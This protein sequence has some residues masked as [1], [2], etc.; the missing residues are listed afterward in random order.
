MT[1]ERKSTR[2]D[3]SG[4]AKKADGLGRVHFPDWTR[5]HTGIAQLDSLFPEYIFCKS[6]WLM[7][8]INFFIIRF[9][10]LNTVVCKLKVNKDVIVN[11]KKKHVLLRDHVQIE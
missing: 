8:P 3:K 7:K 2:R 9:F 11:H 10:F 1:A 6:D 4:R 5:E